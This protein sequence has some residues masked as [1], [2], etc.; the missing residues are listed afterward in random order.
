MDLTHIDL[1]PLPMGGI[2]WDANRN[3]FQ[4]VKASTMK[5][6]YHHLSC[7]ACGQRVGWSRLWLIGLAWSQ[8]P[9]ECCGTLLRFHSVSRL[10]CGLLSGVWG[11]FLYAFIPPH[12]VGF[13]IFLVVGGVGCLGIFR[14]ERISVVRPEEILNMDNTRCSTPPLQSPCP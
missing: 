7:P 14:L 11:G 6:E 3:T 8:W 12:D 13:W 4:G 1:Y 9:C 2:L 10:L 5:P